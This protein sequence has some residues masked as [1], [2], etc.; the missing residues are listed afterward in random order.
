MKRKPHVLWIIECRGKSQARYWAS[1]DHAPWNVFV[2]A[3][4]YVRNL[5]ERDEVGMRYRV[6]KYVREK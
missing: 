4:Q 3:R 2:F 5:N 1:K 6:A